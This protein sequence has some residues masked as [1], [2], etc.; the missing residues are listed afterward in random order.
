MIGRYCGEAVGKNAA[1]QSA[2]E[3]AMQDLDK[4]PGGGKKPEADSWEA[5]ADETDSRGSG[6]GGRNGDRGKAGKSGGRVAGSTGGSKGAGIEPR[7][8]D[9]SPGPSTGMNHDA[10]L[11][12]TLDEAKN[13]LQVG[14]A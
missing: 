5:L 8:K 11:D 2:C 9:P 4:G 6:K 10:V 1:E 12:I 14:V 3:N 13:V 7:G